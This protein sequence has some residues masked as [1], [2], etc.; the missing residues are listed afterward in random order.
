MM[1]LSVHALAKELQCSWRTV[2]RALKKGILVGR[3]ENGRWAIEGSSVVA[4][5]ERL[6]R[7]ATLRQARSRRMRELWR[8]GKLQARRRRIGQPE[9]VIVLRPKTLM[10]ERTQSPIFFRNNEREAEGYCPC[11]R[12]HLRILIG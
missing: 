6:E 11:C 3:W 2:Q 5:R 12:A 1:A 7:L 4:L 10:V 8:L 9:R